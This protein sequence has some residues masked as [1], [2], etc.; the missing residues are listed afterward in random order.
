MTVSR[1]ER[2]PERDRLPTRAERFRDLP[3]RGGSIVWIA[4]LR[5]AGRLAVV[6]YDPAR[7]LPPWIVDE[8]E[9]TRR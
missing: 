1:R 5:V 8:L 7:P 6:G 9:E 3:P 4:P 2:R